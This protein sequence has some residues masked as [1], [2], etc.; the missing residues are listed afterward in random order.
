MWKILII[1][2]LLNLRMNSKI[3]VKSSE[4]NTEVDKSKETS[5]HN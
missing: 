1:F 4:L 5:G 2:I 3:I